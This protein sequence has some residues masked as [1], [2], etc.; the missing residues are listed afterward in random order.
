MSKIKVVAV[1][2]KC[3]NNLIINAKGHIAPCGSCMGFNYKTGFNKGYKTGEHEGK[4]FINGCSYF[5]GF[6]EGKEEGEDKF[7]EMLKK[8]VSCA[9]CGEPLKATDRGNIKPCENCLAK[10]HQETIDNHFI[11]HNEHLVKEGYDKGF[12]RGKNMKQNTLI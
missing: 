4:K 10:E 12:E 5:R 8:R 6:E 7:A 1:C 11:A 9:S 2:S 3:G